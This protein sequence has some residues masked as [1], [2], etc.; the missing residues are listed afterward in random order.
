MATGGAIF[1]RGGTVN[2]TNCSFAGNTAMTPYSTYSESDVLVYGGAIRNEAG[3]IN[4]RS[5]AFLGNS[6]SGGGTPHCR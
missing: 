1:N 5:C 2:A 6:A 3:Q 4:L